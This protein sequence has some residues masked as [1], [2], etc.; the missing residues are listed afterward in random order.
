MFLKCMFGIWI[1]L[2]SILVKP[3]LTAVEQDDG[4]SFKRHVLAEV[5]SLKR[6]PTW[7][8]LP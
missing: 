7:I 6:K 3:G 1:I 5:L 4:V 8:K 2:D